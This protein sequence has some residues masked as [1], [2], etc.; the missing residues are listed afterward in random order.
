MTRNLGWA[1][2]PPSFGQ[3]P[4]EQQLFFV[5]SSL[6]LGKISPTLVT[7]IKYSGFQ[8]FEAVQSPAIVMLL[9]GWRQTVP[10]KKVTFFAFQIIW[11]FY[12][13]L[14]KVEVISIVTP[15]DPSKGHVC[16]DCGVVCFCA[17]LNQESVERTNQKR[18]QR[19]L[20]NGKVYIREK[21]EQ[22]VMAL[23]EKAFAR[24][25]LPWCRGWR[26]TFKEVLY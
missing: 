5:K 7:L 1:L 20:Y 17:V 13:Y 6:T 14:P 11:N 23:T 3:N 22:D 21:R 4:K 18:K 9:H 15:F 24:P 19:N 26:W 10:V 8:D 16:G 25:S 12:Q 2:P